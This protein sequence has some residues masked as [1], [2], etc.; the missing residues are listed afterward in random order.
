ML[1]HRVRHGVFFF[2]KKGDEDLSLPAIT[3]PCLW[4]QLALAKWFQR[5]SIP[6]GRPC[7]PYHLHCQAIRRM[8]NVLQAGAAD[9]LTAVCLHYVTSHSLTTN[10][11]PGPYLAGI[12][13]LLLAGWNV[14]WQMNA[15]QVPRNSHFYRAAQYVCVWEDLRASIEKRGEERGRGKGRDRERTTGSWGGGD[16]RNWAR[17]KPR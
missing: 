2:F 17:L 6:A 8:Q 3:F 7:G 14:L 10:M 12:C 15:C 1:S 5:K 4:F 11:P 9:G 16:G 13:W